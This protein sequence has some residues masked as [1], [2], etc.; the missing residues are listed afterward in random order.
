MNTFSISTPLPN[1][2]VLIVAPHAAHLQMLDLA[3]RLAVRGPLRV[4]D[5]GNQFN[6]LPVARTMRRYT[7]RLEEA[8]V[9]IQLSRAFTCHQ[10]VALLSESSSE[11]IPTL[12][13]DMLSTFYD[14]A[15]PLVESQRLLEV[16]LVHLGRLSHGAPVVVSARPPAALVSERLPLLELLR[17]AAAQY[18]EPEPQPAPPPE[19]GFFSYFGGRA[20]PKPRAF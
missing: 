19:E 1:Q 4:L 14:E 8:L 15:V 16:C 3:A 17:D 11:A 18:W 20:D 7:A 12:V 5:G 13:L 10:M 6:P 2:F 9:S